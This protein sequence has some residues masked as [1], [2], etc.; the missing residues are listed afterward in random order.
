MEILAL[1]F[2]QRAILAGLILSV[3]CSVV[4]VYVVLK[5]LSFIG[6]GIAHSAFGGVALGALLGLNPIGTAMVFSVGVAWLI[7]LASKRGQLSEDATIGIFF[8]VAM[9]FGVICIG[10]QE[11]YTVDLFS[12]LFGSI[13]AVG[14]QDLWLIS[15]LGLLVLFFIAGFFKEL[16]F[17][18]FDE[19]LA[20]VNGIPVTFIFY[21]LLTLIAITVVVSI[22]IVG[23]ILVSSLLVIPGSASYLL[24]H[25]FNWMM[26]YSVLIGTGS[27]MVGLAISYKFDLAAGATIVITSAF[28]FLVC[29][30]FAPKRSKALS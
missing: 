21:M 29:L 8:P 25:R 22:K 3:V 1:E 16:L 6:V 7:G 4:S 14:R 13:L 20:R 2:M 12:Y 11:G 27:T 10:F 24:T 17:F 19:E 26:V 18:I 9:A 30:I 15:L 5:G 28:V 23:I